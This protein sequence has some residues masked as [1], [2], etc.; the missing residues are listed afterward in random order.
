M[1]N[2]L[3]WNKM[4]QKKPKRFAAFVLMEFI[5]KENKNYRASSDIA[6]SW[7]DICNGSFY[8][9]DWT[10]SGF[11]VLND[12]EKYWAGFWFKKH[13]DAVKFQDEYGG[14]GDWMVGYQD[15][16]DSCNE[17]RRRLGG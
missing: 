2:K 5:H 17:E 10:I 11:P 1:K 9:R 15:F 7:D 8:Y 12:G 13:D 16:S 3:G 14:V 6:K 4:L